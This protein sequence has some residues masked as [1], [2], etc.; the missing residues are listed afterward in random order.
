MP[1][2]AT[3]RMGGPLAS[4]DKLYLKG[5]CPDAQFVQ[6][7]LPVRVTVDGIPLP[8]ARIMPGES[9]FSLSFPLPNQLV[10][11]SSVLVSVESDRFFS[12]SKDIRELSLAFGIFEIR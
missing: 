1:R 12:V 7:P 4:G 6:G 11:R 10:G 9:V 2:R 8:G 5:A 3:L